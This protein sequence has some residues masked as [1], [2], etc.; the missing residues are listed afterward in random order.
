MK[1]YI[2]VLCCWVIGLY[3]VVINCFD[4]NNEPDPICPSCHRRVDVTP[5]IKGT[6]GTSGK[7]KIKV[8]VLY[9]NTLITLQSNIIRAHT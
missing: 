7:L 2:F 3:V 9:D 1:A 5:V 4:S 8:Y 6:R